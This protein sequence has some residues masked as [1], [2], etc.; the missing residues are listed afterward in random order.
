MK[1][2]IFTSL[3]F[4][5]VATL[6]CVAQDYSFPANNYR[7]VSNPYYWQNRPPNKGYWQQDVHYKIIA[8]L[9]DSTNIVTGDETLEYWNNSPDTLKYV[10]FHLYSNA[11]NKHSYYTSAY[12]HSGITPKFGK[13][14]SQDLGCQVTG[15]SS[16]NVDL[17]TEVDNTVMKVW[18]NKPILPGY[19]ANFHIKFKT[20]FDNGGTVRNR[21]KMYIAYANKNKDTV[22][23]HFDVVH[24]YP[25]MCVYDKKFGWDVE[26]HLAHEFYGD[27]GTYDIAFTLPNNYIVAATGTLLNEADVMPDSLMKKLNIKNFRSKPMGSAPSVVIKRTNIPKTWLFHAENVHDFALTADPTYRI[28]LSVWHGIQCYSY[29]EEMHASGW[30]NAADY[31]ANVIACNS[32][33]FGMYA[34]PKIIVADANDGMEYPMLTLDGG[35]FPGYLSTFTHEVSHN[36][37]FGMLGSNETYRA[38]LDEGFA[39]FAESWTYKQLNGPYEVQGEPINSYIRS[40]YR[41]DPFV[42]D[43]IYYAYL[44]DYI[45][46]ESDFTENQQG[47]AMATRGGNNYGLRDVT[48]NTQ[49][50][51]FHSMLGHDGGYSQVYTKGAT[52]LYNLQYVLGDS[53][54]FGAMQHYFNEWKFCHPYLEDFRNAITEYTHTDLT[55]FFD[56]WLNTPKSLDYGIRTIKKDTGKNNYIIRFVRKGEMQMP[57]DFTVT[58]NRDSVYNYYIP[59]SWFEKKTNAIT[60]PRWIGWGKVQPYYDAHVHVTGGIAKVQIDTTMRLGDVN[61]LNNT[62]PF[63][64]KYYFDSKVSNSA[65]WANYEAFFGPS[66]WYNGYD[67]AQIGVHMHGDYMMFLHNLGATLYL[68][69]G[70]FQKDGLGTYPHQMVGGTISY[71]TSTEKFIHNSSFNIYAQSLD[72]LDEGKARFQLKDNSKKYTIYTEAQVMYRPHA[73][74]TNYLLYPKLWAVKEY[75]NFIRIGI[76]H[77]YR[78][79]PSGR[80]NIDFNIRGSAINSNYNYSQTTLTLINTQQLGH[81]LTLRT[82]VFGQYGT[83]DIPWESAL[84]AAGANPEQLMDNAFTRAEGIVPQAWTGYGGDINHFQQGGGLDLRG[85]AGYLLPYYYHGNELLYSYSGS[86]GAAINGE[87]DF[88]HLVHFN[89]KFLKNTFSLATYLFGD[90]GIINVTPITLPF[91]TP[92]GLVFANLHADAGVGVALTIQRWGP[93][94]MAKPLTIRFDMPFVLNR[95]PAVESGYVQMR[96]VVGIGRAF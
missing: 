89:P 33:F 36:W 75:N 83:G 15:I 10:F 95:Y 67:G 85:F 2:Q 1:K 47:K 58:S 13:Y 16:D 14:E 42:M 60:L 45:W 30:Q 88:N 54:F 55:W 92:P 59:N 69:T 39:Q 72:G 31:T 37:F 3:L 17:K 38:V 9:N 50:D 93:L 23:K 22:Y 65:D 35:V 81:K 96:W 91:S 57:V 49:S 4:L 8:A 40:N 82:R 26:Q 44:Y 53:L 12:V 7:S 41:K 20:Y 71:Q 18:L 32:H 21:M 62:K 5:M 68:N 80:G 51:D 90:A 48:L 24:W 43:N 78:Y 86:T 46:G 28:G 76:K 84:Y 29:A 6:A 87:L 63:P 64:I 19:S 94:Q 25:R 61:M 27:F 70:I 34:Y 73:W 56:E 74:D 11:Q 77:D 66:L 79:S 52:M